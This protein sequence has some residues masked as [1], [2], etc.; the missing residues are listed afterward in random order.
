MQ[1]PDGG[2]RSPNRVH[3]LRIKSGMTGDRCGKPP[4]GASIA[5]RQPP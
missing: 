4:L 3:G 2:H 1:E 5:A